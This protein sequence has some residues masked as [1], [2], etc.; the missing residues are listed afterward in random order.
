MDRVSKNPASGPY[1]CHFAV[2]Y[3]NKNKNILRKMNFLI[4]NKIGNKNF[5]ISSL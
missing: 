2:S 1:V 3:L 4:P 5:I